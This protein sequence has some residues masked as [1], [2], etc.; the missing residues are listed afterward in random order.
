MSRYEFYKN[1]RINSTH[2][3]FNFVSTGKKGEVIKRVIFGLIEVPNMYNLAFGDVQEDGSIDDI[4]ISNNKDMEK[5]LATIG[6]IVELFF[7]RH[8][9]STVFFMGSTNARTRL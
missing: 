3:V 1:I 2:E 5:I 9:Q 8:P 6:R 7:D 4:S